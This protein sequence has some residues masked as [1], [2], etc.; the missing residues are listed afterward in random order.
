MNMKFLLL[1][2]ALALFLQSCCIHEMPKPPRPDP[3]PDRTR[4]LRLNLNFDQ[5]LPLLGEYVYDQGSI[6]PSRARGPLDAELPHDIRYTINAY[7]I[8]RSGAVSRASD[9][10]II[11]TRRVSE[12]LDASFDIMIPDGDYKLFVWADYV[13]EGSTT[14]K[15]YRTDDFEEIILTDRTAHSGSNP[16]RDAFAGEV[17]TSVLS[18]ADDGTDSR[19]PVTEA[20][21]DMARPMAK[22]QFISTDLQRFI[23]QSRSR[24]EK[25][26]ANRGEEPSR[27]PALSDY[28]V[29]MKY[30]RYMPCS[31]NMFTGKP[32]DSWTGVTYDSSIKQLSDN[33][34]EVAFDY[35][36]VNGAETAITV[37]LEVYD[38]KGT[39]LAAIP[40]FDVPLK[41]SRLTVVKGEF[42]TTK[43]SGSTGINP[44]FEDE[45]N[46]FIQ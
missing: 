21:V 31:F 11:L 39:L 28:R 38:D 6:G 45:F 30:T 37:A 1:P 10:T 32:A 23:E 16:W 18:K 8:S 42:L 17:E 34:A 41:R 3:P 7:G 27:A 5:E 20:T 29:K 46:I 19:T 2:S 44:D 35:V 36:F 14:D 9:T 33:E 24:A 40:P 25:D 26:A 4:S 22:Y 43:A 13:D 12:G 15:Y